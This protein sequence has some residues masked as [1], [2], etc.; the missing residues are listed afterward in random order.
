MVVRDVTDDAGMRIAPIAASIEKHGFP[1]YYGEQ[2]FGI[3]GQTLTLGLDLL[4]GRKSP[5]DIPFQKRKFLLRLALSSV[6]SDLFNQ[7]LAIST[8]RTGC[9]RPS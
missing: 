5:R 7:A 1:N 2:R 9:C 4:A 8:S 3:E 6:Q